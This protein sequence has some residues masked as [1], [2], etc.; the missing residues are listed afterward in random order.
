MDC[1][2]EMDESKDGE[3]AGSIGDDGMDDVAAEI[4]ADQTRE[5]LAQAL[6]KV[7]ILRTD[8]SL[9]SLIG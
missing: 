3:Q 7:S 9:N 8:G 6:T 5:K 4:L 1:G 2:Q